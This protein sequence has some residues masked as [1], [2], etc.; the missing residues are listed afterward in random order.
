M[1]MKASEFEKLTKFNKIL[2]ELEPVISEIY[3]EI[4]KSTARIAVHVLK[5][6]FETF[7][8]EEWTHGSVAASVLVITK[9]VSE[10]LVSDESLANI[11]DEVYKMDYVWKN[12]LK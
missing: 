3:S 6:Y 10:N 7:K 1:G 4:E 12:D 8:D 5:K 11:I 2:E 9:M